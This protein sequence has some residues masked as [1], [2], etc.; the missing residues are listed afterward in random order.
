VRTRIKFCGCTTPDDASSA[1][2]LGVD[3]VGV[4][5]ASAS[6]RC[7]SLRTARD[8]AAV[9]PA[10]VTLVGVFVDPS[11]AELESTRALGFVPQLSG[12]ESAAAR[13]CAARGRYLKVFHVRPGPGGELDPDEFARRSQRYAGATWMF[14]TAVDGR[15]GGTGRS[16]DWDAVRGVAATRRV[17]IGGGLTAENVGPCVRAVRPFGVDVR[18]G[19]E[20]DGVKD[21][22]KMRAFVRAVKETDAQT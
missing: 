17:V 10:F 18:S 14:D 9:V 3:A 16:F 5:F 15:A 6:P 1:V 20:T 2:E 22:T 7:V 21:L 8:I 4:I 19:I 12:E 11:V 13:A